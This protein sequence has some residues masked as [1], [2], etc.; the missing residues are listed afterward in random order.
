M[1]A[2]MNSSLAEFLLCQITSSLRGG[3]MQLYYQYVTRLP[4]VA[5]DPEL[6]QRL[7]SIA[8]SGVAGEPIDTDELN[9]MLYDLYGLS[10]SDITLINDWFDRRSLNS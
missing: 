5:P 2:V 6:Q 1:L 9:G 3:F 10:R 4:I 8:H 7:E